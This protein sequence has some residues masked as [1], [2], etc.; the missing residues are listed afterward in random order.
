MSKKGI[1]SEQGAQAKGARIELGPGKHQSGHQ[2]R[3]TNL[4]TSSGVIILI[5]G[6]LVVLAKWI[7][8]FIFCGEDLQHLQV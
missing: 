2:R 7:L 5:C 4:N 8:Y 1:T 3:D 6:I